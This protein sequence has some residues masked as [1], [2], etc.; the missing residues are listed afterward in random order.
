MTLTAAAGFHASNVIDMAGYTWLQMYWTST[1]TGTVQLQV[2]PD[3]TNWYVA[4]S[5][6]YINTGGGL[7][8]GSSASIQSY[9]PVICHYMPVYGR[10]LRLSTNSTTTGTYT[11]QVVL[12]NSSI[13]NSTAN[14]LLVNAIGSYSGGDAVVDST[15]DVLK[16]IGFQMGYF[17]GASS[18]WMRIRVPNKV[19]S[20]YGNNS[21]NNAIWTPATGRKFRLMR[22]K[23]SIANN[24]A[25]SVAGVQ[26]M[27]FYDGASTILLTENAYLPS[28]ASNTNGAWST[29]WVDLGN[30]VLSATANNVLNLNL[31]KTMIAGQVD[32]VAVGT[33]E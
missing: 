7:S 32:V 33:E 24:A 10:Y 25:V 4:P 20:G 29:G 11:M 13:P 15:G 6:D 27:Q 1:G 22:Y 17:G 9:A 3:N 21:G 16:T 26:V 2:S 5:F 18:Q 28:A 12:S 23:I 30:G 8:T 14:K 31:S 19:V